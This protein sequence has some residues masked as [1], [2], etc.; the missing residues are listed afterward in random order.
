MNIAKYMA[1]ETASKLVRQI[2]EHIVSM[3]KELGQKAYDL[4]VSQMPNEIMNAYGKYP[5]YFNKSSTARIHNGSQVIEVDMSGCV[6]R[7][8]GSY[9][10][11]ALVDVN[12]SEDIYRLQ[13]K[14][15]EE[16]E[17]QSKTYNSI[18]ATLINLR[19]LNKAKECFPEAYEYLKEYEPKAGTQVSLQIE[20]IMQT[21][22][23][24]KK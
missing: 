21:I 2:S 14:L 5:N 4:V 15:K 11:T 18:V 7:K 22:N 20:S 24:Y 9:Y 3:K 1:E 17:R 19:T 12:E 23:S 13:L 8:D 16:K 10:S 6:P